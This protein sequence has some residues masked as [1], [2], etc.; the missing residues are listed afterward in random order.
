MTIGR[1]GVVTADQARRRAA[2]IIARIK[3]G[4]AAVAGLERKGNA[5]TV[6]ELAGRYLD[7][8]VDIRCKPSTAARIRSTLRT[9][10]VPEFGDLWRD[11]RDEMRRL[12]LIVAP[13]SETG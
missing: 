5:L 7:E 8:H 6:A 4:K 11:N 9:H 2:L 13:Q 12:T 10:L 3:S 1:H